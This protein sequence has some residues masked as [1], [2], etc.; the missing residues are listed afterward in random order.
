MFHSASWEH[1][2][3]AT[4]KPVVVTDSAWGEK[5]VLEWVAGGVYSKEGQK[6]S[7]PAFLPTVGLRKTAEAK[8]PDGRR[9]QQESG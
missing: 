9:S 3:G 2:H 1:W 8:P 5:A 6:R 7:T 4:L